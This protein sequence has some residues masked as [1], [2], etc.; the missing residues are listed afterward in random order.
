MDE[1]IIKMVTEM[2]QGGEKSGKKP[3][4][5]LME[6]LSKM[7]EAY[8]TEK[9]ENGEAARRRWQHSRQIKLKISFIEKSF[10]TQTPQANKK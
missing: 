6:L 2:K 3:D 1:S 5:M 4:N 9:R 10:A 8:M 7:S